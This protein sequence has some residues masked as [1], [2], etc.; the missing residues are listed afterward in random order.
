MSIRKRA[1]SLF[2]TFAMC[3][4]ILPSSVWAVETADRQEESVPVGADVVEALPLTVDEV[5][6]AEAAVEDAPALPEDDAPAQVADV[7]MEEGA[8]EPFPDSAVTPEDV[9]VLPE[10]E[11]A[12]E[13]PMPEDAGEFPMGAAAPTPREETSLDNAITPEDEQNAGTV[14]ADEEEA[15]LEEL[16]D[17]TQLTAAGYGSLL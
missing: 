8:D 15:L 16:T 1:L 11:A 13:E 5:T 3:F 2:V 7:P 9:G 6:S 17:E 10:E 4:S 12:V 14:N